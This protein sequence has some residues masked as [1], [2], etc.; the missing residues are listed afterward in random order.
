VQVATS[1]CS[2]QRCPAL[3]VTGIDISPGLQELLHHLSEVIDAAL[4]ISN[5]ST[6]AL[7]SPSPSTPTPHAQTWCS[8]VR[9]SSLARSGLTPLLRNWWTARRRRQIRARL[10]LA[11]LS[12]ASGYLGPL[13]C[14]PGIR[15]G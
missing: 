3:T 13:C 5:L 2:M 7:A 4:Q 12:M 6:T 15:E 1:G 14:C 9:P 11:F 8:A 10:L